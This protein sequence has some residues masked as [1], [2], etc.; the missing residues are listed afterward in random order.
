MNGYTE[1]ILRVNLT[2]RKIDVIPTDKV[3]TVGG[4]PRHGCGHLL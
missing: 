4:W 2:T 1:E 3:Q